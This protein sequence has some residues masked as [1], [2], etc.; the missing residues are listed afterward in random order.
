MENE[1]KISDEVLKNALEK[2]INEQYA[3]LKRTNILFCGNTGAGKS[4]LI[5]V[6]LNENM[7]LLIHQIYL[8]HVLLFFFSFYLY[9]QMIVQ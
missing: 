3:T 9:Q 6:L 2:G 8:L 7:V 1:L 5:N 4:S